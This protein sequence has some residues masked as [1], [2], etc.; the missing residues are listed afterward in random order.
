MKK[1]DIRLFLETYFAGTTVPTTMRAGKFIYF[2]TCK[3]PL[4]LIELGFYTF[5]PI[6]INFTLI[7]IHIGYVIHLSIS[8]EI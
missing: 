5:I 6:P 4:L 7:L 3:H 2:F 1:L 8:S